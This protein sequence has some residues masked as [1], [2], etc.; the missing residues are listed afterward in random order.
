METYL[1]PV[2]EAAKLLNQANTTVENSLRLGV[3]PFGYAIKLEKWR[4]V[5]SRAKLYD[6]LGIPYVWDMENG[7]IKKA[8]EDLAGSTSAKAK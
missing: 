1:V 8:P 5:I 3:A 6:F 7:G 2:P 4:Y